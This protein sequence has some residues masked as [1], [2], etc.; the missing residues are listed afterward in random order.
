MSFTAVTYNILAQAYCHPDRYPHSSER[1]LAAGPRRA[2]LLDRIAA[3]N[4]DLYLLQEVEEDALAAILARLPGHAGEYAQRLGRPDGCALLYRR[5]AFSL[6]GVRTLR[7]RAEEQ[8]ALIGSL[9]QDGHALCAVSTHLRWQPQR[10]PFD[11]HVGRRQ[12]AELL[13][14]LPEGVSPLVCGDFNALSESPPLSQAMSAGLRLSCRSQRPWDTTNINGR[15]RK[16]DY[17]LYEPAWLSPAPGTLPRL[18]RNTPMPSPSEP[19]DHLPV[20]V[21]FDWRR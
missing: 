2:L 1:D 7:Y 5:A 19:S 3:L 6:T 8:V 11:S 10:T 20:K 16:L 21:R 4:A 18:E 13:E 17:L 15:R 14:A 9:A 12:L